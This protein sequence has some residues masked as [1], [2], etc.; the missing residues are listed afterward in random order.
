MAFAYAG[1][2]LEKCNRMGVDLEGRLRADG[3]IDLV[4][5]VGVKMSKDKI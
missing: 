5:I 4:Q 2:Y 3:Y 1:Q